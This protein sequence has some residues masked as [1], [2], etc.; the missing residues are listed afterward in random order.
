MGRDAQAVIVWNGI[1][2]QLPDLTEISVTPESETVKTKPLN[3]APLARIIPQGHSIKIMFDRSDATVETVMAA[4]EAG[5]WSQGT[6]A[7]GTSPNGSLII[8]ITEVA[9]NVTARNYINCAFFLAN[10]GSFS[11]SSPIKMEITGFA[12]QMIVM[13]A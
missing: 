4:A 12:S 7:G 10:A 9:G 13:A 1:T 5:F 6:I 11:A 2:L 8:Y 3:N